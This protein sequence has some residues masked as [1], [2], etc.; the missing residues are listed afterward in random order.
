ML[1]KK[2][3]EGAENL[4]SPKDARKRIVSLLEDPTTACNFLLGNPIGKKMGVSRKTIEGIL[5]PY[6]IVMSGYRTAG[7]A[8]E[9]MK[10]STEFGYI[11]GVQV[12]LTTESGMTVEEV[13]DLYIKLYNASDKTAKIKSM[14][15]LFNKLEKKYFINIMLGELNNKI[16]W[17][18]LKYSLAEKFNKPV[19]DVDLIYKRTNSIERVIEELT[20]G[21]KELAI[22]TPIM[23]QLAKVRDLDTLNYP[24]AAEP[25]MDGFRAQIHI[26]DHVVK[27]FS[28]RNI[29]HEKTKGFPDIVKQVEGYVDGIYDGEILGFKDGKMIS[30]VELQQRITAEK[31]IPELVEKIPCKFTPFD[32][33][34][35]NGE[36]Y[37]NKTYANRTSVLVFELDILCDIWQMNSKE[38]VI[39]YYNT[40][41]AAGFEGVMLKEF[42]GLYEPGVRAWTKYKPAQHSYD[43]VITGARWGIG[44]RKDVLA[45]FDI[46]MKGPNGLINVGS[47]GNGFSDSQLQYLTKLFIMNDSSYDGEPIKQENEYVFP[48]RNM[49]LSFWVV[50]EVITDMVLKNGLRFPRFKC[51]RDKNEIDSWEEV[52][53]IED[54]E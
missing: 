14:L 32:V 50:I 38:E 28:G 51:F 17:G 2:F 53:E 37:L 3:C 16:G 49:F 30:F 33:L 10:D 24:L 26:K 13:R 20:N 12:L 35:F 34:F 40:C 15:P 43:C 22:F 41:I 39:E 48:D 7:E 9:Q 54:D 19:V 23:S 44:N 1:F 18:V 31:G 4:G 5:K 8:A 25:K 21:T 36:S 42:N 47:C 27:I 6:G 46:A 45:S 29:T 52:Q 11:E